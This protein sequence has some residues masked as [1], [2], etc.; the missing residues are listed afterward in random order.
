MTTM[1][2][3]PA[4]VARPATTV[5]P[6]VRDRRPSIARLTVLEIRKSLSTRSGRS[7]AT[8][9]SVLPAVAVGIIFALG[10]KIPS[11]AEMLAVFD[12]LVAMLTVAVGVLATA[13]EWTHQTVQTTFLAVPR[14]H[15]VLTAKY[16]G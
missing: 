6:T 5:T 4:A 15:R 16:A 1:L 13:G 8:A 9:A 14:R 12:T 10:Q 2:T 3:R 11:A 7:I